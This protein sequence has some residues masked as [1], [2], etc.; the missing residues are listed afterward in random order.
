MNLVSS[1]VCRSI[2]F[3]CKIAA[4]M[5]D[6]KIAKCTWL[7]IMLSCELHLALLHNV[8]DDILN[9]VLSMVLA[10]T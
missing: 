3:I 4:I 9:V 5:S 6:V 10:C 7:R 1:H 8:D 2:V